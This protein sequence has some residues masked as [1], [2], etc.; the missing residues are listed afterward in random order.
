[1]QRP[2]FILLASV[3][4][5]AV[6]GIMYFPDIML[7][8]PYGLHFI[9]QSDS[10]AFVRYYMLGAGSL[11]EPG[12][13]D[14]NNAPQQ[15]MTAGEFPIAYWCMAMLARL[16]GA[17]PN[18][19]RVLHLFLVLS[20]LVLIID[21]MRRILRSSVLAL[22]IGLWIMGSPVLIY[23][24]CN[25]L[26]DAAALGMVLFGWGLLLPALNEGRP[27]LSWTS[28]A[29]FT[30]AGMIKAPA[31][32]NLFAVAFT[33]LGLLALNRP[34][35]W[36]R[37][38]L[39]LALK[40]LAGAAIIGAWHFHAIRY[41][42][43]H[44]A[45]YFL[46][47]ATPIWDMNATER[48]ATLDLVWRYWWAKY[49][50]PTSWHVLGILLLIALVAYKR[51]GRG[52]MLALLFL[53][54]ASA[55]FVLLFFRKLADHDYYFLTVVPFLALLALTGVKAIAEA[56]RKPW[57]RVLLVAGVWALGLASLRLAH[58]ELDRRFLA[59]PDSFSQTGR[60]LD[61]FILRNGE[62]DLPG[63]SRIIVLGDRTPNGALSRLG[64]Q[65]WSFPGYPVSRTPR[66]ETL[67]DD[68]ATHVLVIAPET[69]PQWPLAPIASE[70]ACSLWSITR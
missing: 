16:T 61:E 42:T 12:T 20:G 62:Q 55:A 39:G 6:A 41:N 50:H 48:W 9:R 14:L 23:Y 8:D 15:G 5:L 3:T 29:L 13:L 19:L 69:V 53:G 2:A 32:M 17:D 31:T 58:V 52:L 40:A 30:V 54:S 47:S 10:L 25:F 60:V 22:G 18:A 51:V 21:A 59:Q 4:V 7:A 27:A 37:I 56:G 38:S 1:M 57:H 43:L 28:L 49:L 64:R 24:A 33:G 34:E 11:L 70:G 68:G 66:F 36:R 65:G 46:T 67:V 26:P 45:E 44:H 63:S 35:L